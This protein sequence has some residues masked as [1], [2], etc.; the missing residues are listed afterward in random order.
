MRCSGGMPFPAERVPPISRFTGD[1]PCRTE[2]LTIPQNATLLIL[3][4]KLKGKNFEISGTIGI[5][6]KLFE[7]RFL[8]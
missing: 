1:L 8:C 4:Q 2:P 6:S 7:A 5:V 3:Q